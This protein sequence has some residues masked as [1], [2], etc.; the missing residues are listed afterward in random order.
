LAEPETLYCGPR[1]AFVASFVGRT[2]LLSVEVVEPSA[3]PRYLR[4]RLEDGGPDLLVAISGGGASPL[5]GTR[6][7]LGFRPECATISDSATNRLDAK[8]DDLRYFGATRCVSLTTST[9]H[10][11]EVDLA[12]GVAAPAR[13]QTVSI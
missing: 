4:V 6:F 1:S 12:A 3:D 11:V 7:L 10:A 8:V 5:P 2:N 9:G 13:Q